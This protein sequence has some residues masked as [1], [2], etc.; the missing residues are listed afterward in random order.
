METVPSIDL[1]AQLAALAA[2]EEYPIWEPEGVPHF[3]TWLYVSSVVRTR[4]PTLR[5][6]IYF[7]TEDEWH[8]HAPINHTHCCAA[9]P[10]RPPALL[11][12]EE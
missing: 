8:S 4:H 2:R 1:S 12:N 6:W 10:N 3:P 11:P 9:P 5:K 7:H